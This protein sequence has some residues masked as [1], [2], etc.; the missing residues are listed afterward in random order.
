MPLNGVQNLTVEK[1]AKKKEDAPPVS[2]GNTRMHLR[3]SSRLML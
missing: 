2:A 1:K 3:S